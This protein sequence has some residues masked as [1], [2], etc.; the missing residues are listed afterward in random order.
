MGLFWVRGA[1]FSE[2]HKEIFLGF[3]IRRCSF[4]I[5]GAGLSHSMA[6]DFSL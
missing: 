3:S 6:L 5:V 1:D 2:F 4:W